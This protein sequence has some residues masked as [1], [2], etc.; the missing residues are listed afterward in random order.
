M[1]FFSK[2]PPNEREESTSANNFTRANVIPTEMIHM[3]ETPSTDHTIHTIPAD[4]NELIHNDNN[5]LYEE[6]DQM[7]IFAGYE[8]PLTNESSHKMLSFDSVIAPDLQENDISTTNIFNNFGSIGFSPEKNRLRAGPDTTMTSIDFNS[9]RSVFPEKPNKKNISCKTIESGWSLD[10][11]DISQSISS[12]EHTNTTLHAFNPIEDSP[13]DHPSFAIPTQNLFMS[14]PASIP[15]F[16]FHSA[17]IPSKFTLNNNATEWDDLPKLTM[18]MVIKRKQLGA[19]RAYER[20]FGANKRP[21][22]ETLNESFTLNTPTTYMKKEKYLQPTSTFGSFNTRITNLPK[23]NS[24]ELYP[25]S[26]QSGYNSTTF[27]SFNTRIGNSAS[28][29]APFK[30]GKEKKTKEMPR[31]TRE[32]LMQ[33]KKLAAR[34][35]LD[36]L[37][38]ERYKP[39]STTKME[40]NNN[41]NIFAMRT[42]NSSYSMQTENNNLHEKYPITIDAKR[43]TTHPNVFKSFLSF[44]ESAFNE[45]IAI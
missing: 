35:S 20:L 27:D 1:K 9:V 18:E 29:P 30:I 43:R 38:N 6:K 32:R 21:R 3:E 4:F 40:V 33:G 34:R 25:V 45:S 41:D 39:R 13:L 15:M 42:M 28:I 44:G 36:R 37:F 31:L 11:P 22:T 23:V 17:A 8:T 16:N 10:T 19:R 24:T 7:S 14:T 26:S 2:N 12:T 5:P